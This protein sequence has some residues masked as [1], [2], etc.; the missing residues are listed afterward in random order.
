MRSVGRI[1]KLV[2][3]F[4]GAVWLG[5]I[6]GLPGECGSG[7]RY[8]YWKRRLK[9]IGKGVRIDCGVYFQ[10]PQYISV[11]DNTWIDRNVIILAGLDR[12]QREK[13]RIE[14]PDYLYEQGHVHIGSHIHIPP[15]C[16]ISGIDSGVYISDGCGLAAGCKIYAFSHHYRSAKDPQ[17]KNIKFGSMVPPDEQCLMSG[18]VY[19][20][21]NVGLA[22]NTVILPGVSIRENSFVAINS[23]VYKGRY[24]ANSL[25]QGSPA[26]V[27]GERFK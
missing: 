6:T 2:I 9:T 27:V 12:S 10:N 8:S 23:V 7:L 24:P 14:N 15:N 25:L 18:P 11:G 26:K 1:I 21:A 17:N 22:L 4:P 19:L 3:S 20:G 16:I 5:F 13:I